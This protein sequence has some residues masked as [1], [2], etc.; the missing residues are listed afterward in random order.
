MEIYDEDMFITGQE[1]ALKMTKNDAL[2]VVDVSRANYT[3]YPELVRRS[4]C[5]L[6]LTITDKVRTL[7]TMHSY[8]I[9]NY[10]IFY[11]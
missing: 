5:L 9:L 10:H 11:M 2:I 1:A 3:E 4:Q 7:L 6:Y 8:L